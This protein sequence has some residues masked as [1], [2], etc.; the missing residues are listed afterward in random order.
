MSE[1]QSRFSGLFWKVVLVGVLTVAMLWPLS[2]VQGLVAERQGLQREA[3]ERIAAANGGAQRIGAPILMVPVERPVIEE[4]K[5]HE[6]KLLWVQAEPL[7]L[8]ADSVAMSTDIAVVT[9]H[10]CIY[11]LPT[12]TAPLHLQGVFRSAA[13]QNWRRADEGERARWDRAVLLVPVMELKSL[14]GI[15][16][17][18]IAGLTP[19]AETGRY[20][21]LE[22][23]RFAVDLTAA[24]AAPS[25]AFA[26]DLQLGGSSALS[27]VPLAG[28]TQVA[29]QSNWPH[30]DFNGTFLPA[31]SHVDAGGFQAKWRIIGLN[32]AIAQQWRGDEVS[33]EAINAA[34]FGVGLYQPVDLYA[35]NYRAVRYGLLFIAITFLCFFAWEHGSKDVRLHPMQYLLVGLALAVFYLLLIALSEHLGFARA[36]LT[37]ATALVLLVTVYLLGATGKRLASIIVGTGIAFSYSLLYLILL[38]EDY[39]LLFGALLVFT[40]LSIL[41]LATRKLDWNVVARRSV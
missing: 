3:Q 21:G 9:R 35:Q 25:I 6:K 36:Y 34:S 17:V 20:A 31:S 22:G 32:R 33:A 27:F 40:V 15:D 28:D 12:Y 39:A 29:A 37:A 1:S 19:K 13:L 2:L 8:L 24:L 4:N 14:H 41:M 11:T 7:R 16:K 23:V 10:K 38:S 30:P 26:M 18:Q 5:S